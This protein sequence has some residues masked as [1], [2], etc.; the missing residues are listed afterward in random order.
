[1]TD[2]QITLKDD[3]TKDLLTEENG[4]KTLLESAVNQILE[5]QMTEY[6]G[7][8]AYERSEERKD[9]RNGYRIREF[10]TRVGP[11]LLRIPQTR[12]GHFRTDIFERYQRSEKALV[13][14]MME[15]VVKGVSTR[16]VSS[17]TEKLCGS[18]F[19]KSTVSQLCKTLDVDVKAW[20]NRPLEKQ[21]PFLI[22]DALFTKVRWDHAVRSTCALLAIGITKEGQ[23][24]ILGLQ[25]GDSESYATWEDMFSWLKGRGL[26][27][28]DLVTS[29][30]HKGLVRAA[31]K[32]FQGALWQRCQVHFMRN[33]LGH[34][35]KRLREPMSEGLKRLFRSESREEAIK[36]A[37]YLAEAFEKKAPKAI[38]RLEL[39]IEDTLSVLVFPSKYRKRMKSTNMVERLNGEIRRREKVIRIFPN[40]DSALR[41]IGALLMEQHE[42][43]STGRKYLDM[44]DYTLW[45]QEN[46]NVFDRKVVK[47]A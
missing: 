19:S 13:L 24:E 36:Q 21:Y 12:H 16:K 20:N 8:E 17:I 26:K 11:L 44:D 34:T 14:S 43:W 29:D 32:H 2:Y 33:I 18:S 47:F 41:M 38:E 30:E 4:L 3:P 25:L 22:I 6:I 10:S 27:G 40:K 35:P 9:Y 5:A 37:E 42:V 23:R 15:M 46:E 1:M 31:Q 28:V 7:A 45:R 39:G